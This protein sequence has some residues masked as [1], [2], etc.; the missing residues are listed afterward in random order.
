[1]GERAAGL[2]WDPRFPSRTP[3]L[4]PLAG[5]AAPLAGLADWPDHARL[6]SL[7]PGPA[8]WPRNARGLPIRF[9]PPAAPGPDQPCYEERIAA[10]GEVPTR[11]ANWHDLFNA[12]VWIAFPRSKSALN[13]RH[14]VARAA[15]AE[16]SRRSPVED[17]LAGFDESGV[18]VACAEPE[19]EALLRG[20]RWRELFWE[21]RERVRAGMRFFLFGHGLCEAALSPFIGLTGKGVIVTMEQD[22]FGAAPAAQLD[23]LDRRLAALIAD[24]GWLLAPR[25]LA[26]VPLLGV[27]GWWPANETESFYADTNY[28]RPGR[29]SAAP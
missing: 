8:G 16:S 13:A 29:R 25:E 12:V 23:A 7:T 17:T 20:F 19:L 4:A 9:V 22:F 21:S 26:P 3:M 10:S 2:A 28:F 14:G 15:R 1:M 24:P 27:P 11:G 18:A 6:N 5:V